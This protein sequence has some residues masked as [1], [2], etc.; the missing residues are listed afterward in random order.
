MTNCA[1][2]WRSPLELRHTA[3]SFPLYHIC[4]DCTHLNCNA[5]PKGLRTDHPVLVYKTSEIYGTV[6]RLFSCQPPLDTIEPSTLPLAFALLC[7][8]L[9]HLCLY[10]SH[11]Q[12]QALIATHLLP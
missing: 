7:L 3:D 2:L 11:L 8:L 1:A 10:Y 12:L 9:S 6:L 5:S 4:I